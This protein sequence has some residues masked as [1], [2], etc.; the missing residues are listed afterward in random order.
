MTASYLRLT[1]YDPIVARDGRPFGVGQGNRMRGLAWP[2]PS[3]IAGSF[4]TALVKATAGRDFFGN[5]PQQLMGI[6]VAGVFPST[7]D[8]LYLPAPHDCIVEVDKKQYIPHRAAPTETKPGEGCDWPGELPLLPVVIEPEGDFKPATGPAWWSASSLADWLTRKPVTF[9][10]TFC[11]AA[12]SQV[13]DHV[14]L[15]PESGASAENRLF[16]TAGLSLTHLPRFGVTE[17]TFSERFAPITLAARVEADAWSFSELN[18]LHPLGGERR[19][20]HWQANGN[21]DLWKPLVDEQTLAGAVQVRMVLATPA[22]FDHGWRPQWLDARSL[23]GTPPGADVRL[24]LV[25]VCIQ[26]WKAVSGWSLAEP[27]GPKP[28]K[29]L[30]PAGGVYFFKTISGDPGTLAK[31]WLQPVSDTLQD[32]ND[33][34]GLAVWGTW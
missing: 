31:C 21:A 28:V 25:G 13:R 33:G 9:D 6:P 27:R 3:V 14:E 22:V 7:E 15:E 1:A 34:F 32:R 17:G 18:L 10:Q 29:R 26:R 24:Q 5:V 11:A 16:A 19:L 12:R 8:A 30:V 2:Y 20:V 23:E 4:R